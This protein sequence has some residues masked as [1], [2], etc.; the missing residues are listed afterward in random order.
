MLLDG[1]RGFEELGDSSFRELSG[2]GGQGEPDVGLTLSLFYQ[3]VLDRE[4][5]SSSLDRILEDTL[6]DNSK[7][8]SDFAKTH[9][10][11]VAEDVCDCFVAVASPVRL[12]AVSH[13]VLEEGQVL[14]RSLLLE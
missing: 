14:H 11:A 10:V 12:Q 6:S 3:H 13:H 2:L 7:R 4:L 9:L 1:T 5:S 8:L